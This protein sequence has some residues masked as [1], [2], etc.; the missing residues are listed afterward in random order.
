MEEQMAGVTQR[1]ESRI[2]R[3]TFRRGLGAIIEDVR[4]SVSAR[5]GRPEMDLKSWS[6][7]VRCF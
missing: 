6:L 1:R 4:Q 7:V 3:A 5:A 2:G